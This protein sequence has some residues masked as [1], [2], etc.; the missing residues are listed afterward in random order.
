MA[1]RYRG[2]GLSAL[3]GLDIFL[4]TLLGGRVE[5]ISARIGRSIQLNG[6]AGRVPWPAPLRRHFLAAARE[7]AS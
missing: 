1:N 2:Y 7:T 6:W 4:N 3:I 5:T